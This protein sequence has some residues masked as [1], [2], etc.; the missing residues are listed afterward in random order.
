MAIRS[1]N[2]ESPDA[3]GG[4]A[5]NGMAVAAELVRARREAGLTQR[6]LADRLKLR[7]WTI[8]QWETGAKAISPDELQAVAAALGVTAGRLLG[9][10]A[11]AEAEP[12]Q[13]S[14][15]PVDA[16]VRVR[17][18][19]EQ[20]RNPELPRGLRGYEE[21][22]TRRLLANIAF[23]HEGMLV[24]HD[25]LAQ[26]VEELQAAVAARE[27]YDA[28]VSELRRRA[29]ELVRERDGLRRRIEELGAVAR[30]RDELR[31]RVEEL[32]AAREESA[33]T[34]QVLSKALLAASRAAEELLQE[35]RAEADAKLAAARAAV[36]DAEREIEERWRSFE[37]DRDALLTALRGEA[38]GAA[39]TDLTALQR[40][41]E[42]LV[43]A[44]AAFAGR[45]R[46]I[47]QLDVGGPEEHANELLDDLKAPPKG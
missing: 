46:T 7:L 10:D 2:D 4:A 31:A 28:I 5:S 45:I 11:P 14:T 44:L 6:E 1:R 8:D 32:E 23:L 43:E 47:G 19:A 20:I 9:R 12:P 30:E 38:L 27:D 36:Q 16:S 15:E 21:E 37:S 25:E 34:E 33:D 41:A 29:D 18:T 42:P 26:R 3:T 40:G 22:A 13:M 39:R 17:L 35:A 24:E